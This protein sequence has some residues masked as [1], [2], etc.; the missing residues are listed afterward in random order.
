MLEEDK[1]DVML[2]SNIIQYAHSWN[3]GQSQEVGEIEFLTMVKNLSKNLN[4]GGVIQI[5]YAYKNRL[6]K[7]KKY[8]KLLGRGTVSSAAITFQVGPILYKPDE[9]SESVEM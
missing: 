8:T 3:G 5:D 2:L 9:M 4:K 7:Y 6:G 1:Y